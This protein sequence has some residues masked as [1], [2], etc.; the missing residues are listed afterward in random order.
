MGLYGKTVRRYS[1]G[2]AYI[3]ALLLLALFSTLALAI[4]TQATVGLRQSSNSCDAMNARMTAESG[5]AFMLGVLRDVTLPPETTDQTLI[6]NLGERL[7]SRLDDTPNLADGAVTHDSV[8]S[9]PAI[10]WQR[11]SFRCTF[12][13][14]GDS[15][16][17]LIV[18]GTM[19]DAARTISIDLSLVG[20][21]KGVFG[22]GIASKGKIG[23]WGTSLLTG[24]NEPGEANV[25]SILDQAEAIELCGNTT[26]GGEL[27]LSD[28]AATVGIR[29]NSVTVNGTSGRDDI[30]ENHVHRVAEPEFPVVSTESLASLADNVLDAS[31]NY[32]RNTY[33]NIRIKSRTNPQFGNDVV[34]NGI[35]YIEAPNT[36]T[37]KND[38]TVNGMIITEDGSSYGVD[39][40][41]LIFKSKVTCLG[42][43]TLP[44]TPEFSRVK[45]HTGTFVLA[46]GFA[47]EFRGQVN[48]IN[49]TIAADRFDF[50]GNCNLTIK[51]FILGLSKQAMTFHGNNIVTI[52]ATN[53]DRTPAGLLVPKQLVPVQGTYREVIGGA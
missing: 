20:Q 17:R 21:T 38:C 42:V 52:D 12:S 4:T 39:N 27:N 26:I 10:A 32:N 46:P 51:G 15:R 3:L 25:L 9:V 45:E 35:V 8:V 5:L 23:V 53:A 50:R 48:T 11:G 33:N 24:A 14:I 44:E 6:L 31:S 28:P 19:K 30:L 22:Y 7:A 29:G 47:V 34:L 41:Q 2:V 49:G 13:P 36:V 16:C 43:E 18:T 37:F 40:C 1:S